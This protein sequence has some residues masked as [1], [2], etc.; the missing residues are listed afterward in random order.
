M[1]S[2]LARTMALLVAT[3]CLF[4]CEL[5]TSVDPAQ[6]GQGDPSGTGGMTATSSTGGL[7]GMGGMAGTLC[8]DPQQQC[9][10]PGTAC[11]MPICDNGAC[12][13][14]HAPIGTPCNDNGGQFCNGGG[15]CIGCNAA[16]EC[17]SGYCV[18]GVCCD[19]ACTGECQ[20]CNVP[21]SIGTCSNIPAGSDPDNECSGSNVCSA[22][23]CV[24]AMGLPNPPMLDVAPPHAW[25]D[26]NGDGQ[27]DVIGRSSETTI[28]VQRGRGNGTFDDPI[29]YPTGN[30]P[31]LTKP[32]DLNGD[33]KPDL[34]VANQKSDTVSVLL[35]K[36]DGTFATKKDYG[37]VN[38]EKSA[39]VADLNSDG[40]PDLA[41]TTAWY[42]GTLS[43][44][45]NSGGGAFGARVDYATSVNP[46]SMIAADLNGDG[47]LDLVVIHSFDSTISV[48][49]NMGNGTFAPKVDYASS[50]FPQLVEAADLNGD[51][52]V[53]LVVATNSDTTPLEVLLNQGDGTFQPL[54][55]SSYINDGVVPTSLV[56]E[57]VN[58]D[59]VPDVVIGEVDSICVAS[60]WNHGIGV[61]IGNGDG[62]FV[63]AKHYAIPPLADS[64]AVEDLNGDGTPDLAAA[65]PTSVTVLLNN[66]SGN[67]GV[68][69]VYDVRNINTPIRVV[70]VDMNGDGS[71]ELDV[72][73]VVLMNK[74]DGTFVNSNAYPLP[75]PSPY[76]TDSVIAD[77]NGDGSLDVAITHIRKGPLGYGDGGIWVYLNGGNGTFALAGDYAV[78]TAPLPIVAVDV[79]GDNRVDLAAKEWGGDT[80]AVYVLLNKGDGTFTAPVSYFAGGDAFWAIVDVNGDAMADIMSTSGYPLEVLHVLINN[81]NGTFAPKVDYPT[82]LRYVDNQVRA[83]DLNG[84]G[85]A[86]LI[87]ASKSQGTQTISVLMNNGNGTF[88]ARVDYPMGIYEV[89]MHDRDIALADLNGDA[90][91]DLL[92]TWTWPSQTLTVAMNNG[93]GTFAPKVDYL[94]NDY[95]SDVIAGDLNG[96]GV[97][98]LVVNGTKSSVIMNNGDGTLAPAIAYDFDWATSG[99]VDMNGDGNQDLIA[100]G[101]IALNNGNGTFARASCYPSY[102]QIADLNGDGRLDFLEVD[103]YGPRMRVSMNMCLP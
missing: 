29:E 40:Q 59:G 5:I 91:A 18:D 62:T 100:G 34:V 36:G 14:V 64:V 44:F 22:G 95:A 83:A 37:I 74:G 79:N 78:G 98:D 61:L 54:P 42:P 4:G 16:E 49:L 6:I 3:C 38:G 97:V 93:D 39:L 58:G 92:F 41:V 17:A 76:E 85:L 13:V 56:V 20:A 43:V 11:I 32:I 23:G 65:N 27:I 45:L 9:P 1:K 72:S 63:P 19:N 84:D 94:V 67:F 89:G 55:F 8:T 102:G 35:N 88:A 69:G 80:D 90:R 33:G 26:V 73:R 12:A 31:L 86:E 2:S 101:C 15:V 30:E 21:G 47:T 24:C 87:Y 66:G 99:I 25:V 28:G 68:A 60:C 81:G 46:E 71:P 70:A 7:G 48:W 10:D 52:H 50:A 51:S 57:D 96:D 77:L 53:D 103:L 82:G 75:D